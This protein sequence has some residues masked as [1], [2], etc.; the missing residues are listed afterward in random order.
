[1]ANLRNIY[2]SRRIWKVVFLAISLLL[3]A[4]FLYISNNLVKDLAVQERE[5]MEIWANATQELASLGNESSEGD[6]AASAV[7]VDFL[8]S[9]I[10]ANHNIPVLLVDDVLTTGT[11]ARRCAEALRAGGAVKVTLLAFTRALGHL[12]A[13]PGSI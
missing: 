12:S 3:V 1:M 4:L 8:F 11:T 5:R 6:V 9:I 13:G 2:D 10:E 7:N